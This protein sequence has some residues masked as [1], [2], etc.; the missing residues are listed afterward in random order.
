MRTTASW[1]G[2]SDFRF[3][4][5]DAF[6][7]RGM[8]F[9]GQPSAEPHHE[10]RAAR[11]AGSTPRTRGGSSASIIAAAPKRSSAT[12]ASSPSTWATVYWPI[13][14]TPKR[15]NMMLNGQFAP[16]SILSRRFRSSPRMPVHPYRFAS[17]SPPGSS[18]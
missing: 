13:S 3:D 11:Q 1:F 17:A 5:R 14:A 7:G 18:W 8:I 10:R 6:R 15:V 4:S 16:G 2:S 9:W 12:A